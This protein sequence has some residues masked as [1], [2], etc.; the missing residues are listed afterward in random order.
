MK[1]LLLLFFFVIIWN[2]LFAQT[3][4]E[5]I[6]Q[7]ANSL[8]VPFDDLR[9]FVQTY[10]RKDTSAIQGTMVP[11]SNLTAKL[12]WLQKSAE[13]HNTYILEVNANENIAPTRL[14]YEGAINITVVLR[15]NGVNRTIRLSTNGLMFEV[16]KQ[17]TFILENNITLQGHN[18]NTSELVNVD[19]GTFKMNAGTAIIGNNRSNGN[20]GG[21]SV[22]SR[23]TFEMSGGTISGNSARGNGGGV[24]IYYDGNFTMTG[25][26]ISGNN[27][28]GIGGG[29][30]I[31]TGTF[32]MDNGTI[33]G[34]TAKNGGGVCGNF[35]MRGGTITG[36]TAR[37]AGG[38]VFAQQNSFKK[39][40]GT[41][42]GYNSD[43]ANGNVVR[44]ESG[45][46]LARK[47]H[48]VF[49]R[50]DR[51]KETTAGPGVSMD[52]DTAQGWDQ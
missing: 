44:D 43:Q 10:Q 31:E 42:T 6:R 51:R 20:A 18:G 27:A 33:S 11:G 49:V 5:Q 29:V 38:G 36:N 24:H 23:G 17:V 32:T 15:G 25:G 47:G 14:Y 40:G 48:A 22:S 34:N 1:K 16:Q 2:G 13:S 12:A 52:R 19:E 41:I 4:D 50:A 9:Q 39:T 28:G 3:T 21:V 7:A 26:T 30:N 46:V 45:D 37:E 8:G 35:T